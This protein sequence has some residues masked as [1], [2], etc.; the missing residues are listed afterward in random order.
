LKFLFMYFIFKMT[1]YSLVS[2]LLFYYRVDN[3]S[4]FFKTPAMQVI[5][6][7][8]A[9]SFFRCTFEILYTFI[10][11]F[12]GQSANKCCVYPYILRRKCGVRFEGVEVT[13]ECSYELMSISRVMGL[14]YFSC[15]GRGNLR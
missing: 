15:K 10:K 8:F 5:N 13:G 1:A 12:R 3:F 2:P 7:C 11:Y 14:F 4:E 6:F 9:P